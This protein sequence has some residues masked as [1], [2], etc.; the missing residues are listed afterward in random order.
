MAGGCVITMQPAANL[1]TAPLS[2]NLKLRP[3]IHPSIR[4]FLTQP[5][6]LHNLCDGFGSPL[7]VM[8]PENIDENI[9]SFQAAY[10]KNH[11]RG[12]IYFTS[13]P[14]KSQALVRRA[15]LAPI[16]IDVSS[17]QSLKHVMNC[18]FSPDR[19]EATGPKNAEYI[20]TCLQLD[21]LLNADSMAELLLIKELRGKLGLSRK[22]RVMVRLS[23]FESA[24]MRFTPQDGTF[25]IHTRDVPAVIDWLVNNKDEID[26][27]GFSFYISGA[28]VEQRVVAIENQLQLTFLAMQKGLKPRGID[29]G[30]G[31]SVQYA[32]D[33]MEWNNYL[34]ALKQSVAGEIENQTWNN[35]GLGYRNVNGVVAGAPLVVNH[36]PSHTKGEELDFW[37]NQRS[38][39]FGNALLTDLIRDSLLELYI[40]PGRGMLDQCGITVGRVAFIKESTWGELLTGLE[41]NRSNNHAQNLKQLCDPVIIPRHPERNQPNA[42]GVYYVGN[43]CVSYDILQYNKTYPDIVPERGDLVVFS[44]T[45]AYMM[46]FV[47]SETLMQPLAQKVAVWRDSQ[48]KFRWALDSQYL[49]IKVSL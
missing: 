22:A 41:M 24:R 17:P 14:C 46:D 34:E 40:E 20:L 4:D 48:D 49:P 7:N 44:N 10:K 12:R 11:L 19:I 35:S 42:R 30:G 38:V 16:G 6:L 26:F 32:E 13:K 36:V 37:L 5:E 33:M 18:G 27:H 29:I 21:V 8:F 15:S 39:G 1:N 43:L 25:G 28:S 2:D 47:E 3:R 45:A 9:K 31:F 23:G